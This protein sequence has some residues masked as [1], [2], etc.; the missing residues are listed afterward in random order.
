M[1]I[2][3]G[4]F[5][6]P[7]AFFSTGL[8]PFLLWQGWNV[9]ISRILMLADCEGLLVHIVVGPREMILKVSNNTMSWEPSSLSQI[10]VKPSILGQFSKTVQLNCH[11]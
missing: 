1:L 10:R 8:F 2:I 4:L 6:N 7:W 5:L 3:R 9:I 11:L